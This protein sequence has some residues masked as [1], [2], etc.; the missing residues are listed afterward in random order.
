MTT[1]DLVTGIVDVHG[2][3]GA[4]DLE[5][6]KAGG[7]VAFIHKATEGGDFIDK[8]FARVLPTLKPAGLLAGAYHFANG[9][10]AVKQA[11]NYLRAIDALGG[12][13]VL[14]VLDLETNDRSRFGTMSF[15]A[16]AAW[17]RFV[18][19][20]RGRWPLFY[21]YESMLHREMG[22]A[23]AETR[24]T[25]GKCPL[26]IAK[27]G[28]PPK[29]MPA[30]WGAWSDWSLWQY[31]SSVENGPADQARYPRGVPGFK[32]RSQDR[33]VFRG[34]VDELTLWWKLCGRDP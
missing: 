30:R 15:D 33:N 14:D 3:D 10:D 18:R 28:P 34:T 8:A 5:A 25:L 7:G 12:L 31:T 11:E 6:F 22:K 23:S 27:Y 9:T 13:D 26:W 16:G 24:A 32:R 21:T 29:A 1:S 4:C 2:P 19:D 20:R 17:A